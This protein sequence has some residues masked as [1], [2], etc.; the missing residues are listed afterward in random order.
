MFY[1]QHGIFIVAFIKQTFFVQ[2]KNTFIPASGYFF[3]CFHMAMIL[4]KNRPRLRGKF[5]SMS[6]GT[7][8]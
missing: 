4:K 1:K 6:C 7:W 8:S 2:S 3:C 5:N